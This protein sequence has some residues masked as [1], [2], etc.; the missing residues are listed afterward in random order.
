MNPIDLLFLPILA[1]VLA[2]TLILSWRFTP[3]PKPGPTTDLYPR[4][5]AGMESFADRIERERWDCEFIGGP[6]DGFRMELTYRPDRS[7]I[8]RAVYEPG[9]VDGRGRVRMEFAGW[10]S[11]EMSNHGVG[12]C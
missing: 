11:P 6:M 9:P 8:D 3:A 5:A 12:E 4:M 10:A 1:V 7:Y 2:L